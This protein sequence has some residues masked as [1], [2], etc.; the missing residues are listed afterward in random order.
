M[1]IIH[2]QPPMIQQNKTMTLSMALSIPQ[3]PLWFTNPCGIGVD[4]LHPKSDMSFSFLKQK[5]K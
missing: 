3:K 5:S 2:S 1:I 4:P